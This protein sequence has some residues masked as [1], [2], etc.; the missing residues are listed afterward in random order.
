M[1]LPSAAVAVSLGCLIVAS[2]SAQTSPLPAA[3]SSSP[4]ST[5]P[6]PAD[7][8]RRERVTAAMTALAAAFERTIATAPEQWW[9]V[10]FPIWP[11]LETANG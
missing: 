5:V 4:T 11:D 7:G 9:A 10:F 2:V 1:K 8:T 3:A 6:V